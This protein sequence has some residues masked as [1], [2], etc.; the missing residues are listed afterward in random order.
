MPQI[1]N[2]SHFPPGGFTVLHPEAGMKKPFSGSFNAAVTFEYEFRK[3]N[4]S[5]AQR[6]K[7]PP[8]LKSCEVWVDEQNALRCIANGWNH[9]VTFN[10]DSTGVPS[11]LAEKK[12][13]LL[14][15]V[16][17]V[18]KASRAGVGVWLDMFGPDGKPVDDALAEKRAG[19]CAACVENDRSDNLYDYFVEAL[20]GKVKT[21]YEMLRNLSLATSHDAELGVC[22]VCL[23]PL[24][25]KVHCKLAHIKKHMADDVRTKLPLS[26]WILT[27]P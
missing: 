4:P 23:C 15:R 8:D 14:G 13:T 22:K 19:I 18:A 25:A 6:L 7:L 5:L 10:F 9:F 26:C 20:V 2:R 12:T 21:V 27:E 24:K 3:K 17:A 1:L 11:A 16:V